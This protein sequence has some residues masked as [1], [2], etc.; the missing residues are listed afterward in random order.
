MKLRI[1]VA[2]LFLAAASLVN[3]NAANAVII[4]PVSSLVSQTNIMLFGNDPAN[5]EY[6]NTMEVGQSGTINFG[7]ISFPWNGS[8]EYTISAAIP[9][10]SMIT[11]TYNTSGF[12]PDMGSAT[13]QAQSFTTEDS[14]YAMAT[15]SEGSFSFDT[16]ASLA[17]VSAQFVD[18][19]SSIAQHVFKNLSENSIW[20]TSFMEQLYAMG[21]TAG[22]SVSYDV[23]AVPVP[24]ALPMF[25]IGLAA[26]IG[27]R[28][29]KKAA[30]ITA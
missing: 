24:A 6:T 14:V 29:K 9:Q 12:V 7:S 17:Y 4:P 18:G 27:L 2:T 20:I 16:L 26:M 23:S 28:R 15:P 22:L 30:K 21:N 10:N 13:A 11:F 25:A 19:D 8:A 3:A 1:I 5:D